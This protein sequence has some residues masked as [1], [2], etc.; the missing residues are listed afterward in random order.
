MKGVGDEGE[1]VDGITY[2]TV[3]AVIRMLL[4]QQQ[5]SPTTS[6]SRKNAVSIASRINILLD[7]ESPMTVRRA[8]AIGWR[9][10]EG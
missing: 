7:L 3:S 2:A 1:R 8:E 6:S 9:G 5:Y 4:G 10:S